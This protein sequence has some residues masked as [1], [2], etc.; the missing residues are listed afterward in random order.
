MKNNDF[1]VFFLS[2][3][4]EPARE[5]KMASMS[6]PISELDENLFNFADRDEERNFY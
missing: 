4:A 1:F 2:L 5:F 6:T 3:A